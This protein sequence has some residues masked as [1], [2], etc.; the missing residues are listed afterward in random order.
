[1]SVAADRMIEPESDMIVGETFFPEPKGKE[2]KNETKE[3]G[4]VVVISVNKAQSK[5]R[6]KVKGI[7]FYYKDDEQWM[8][9][10][11]KY[12]ALKHSSKNF[13][14]VLRHMFSKNP[15]KFM[16]CGFGINTCL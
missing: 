4:K 9:N 14:L 7:C 16:V 12:L 8:R 13:L 2:D 11:P 3:D 15:P 10:C 1:V 6:G 5:S